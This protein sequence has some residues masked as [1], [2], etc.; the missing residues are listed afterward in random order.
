MDTVDY[1]K[2]A[3]SIAL[4]FLAGAIGSIFTFSAIPTWYQ[5]LNKPFFN[6]PNWVFGLVWT[7]LYVLMG[8]SLYLVWNIKTGKEKKDKKQ[9]YHYFGIQL[10]LNA[11]WSIIFFGFHSPDLALSE[12]IFLW[13]AIFWTIKTFYQFS[14]IASYLLIPYLAW[15]SFATILNLFIVRFN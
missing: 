2:L 9:A 14:K 10:G 3:L 13:I 15:V 5:T 12:I 6:P 11:L 4:P 7:L 1:R 8:I